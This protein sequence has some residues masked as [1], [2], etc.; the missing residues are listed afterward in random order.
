[1]PVRFKKTVAV[2]DGICTVEESEQLLEW[3]GQHPKGKVNLK[4]C[5]HLHSAVLQ[6]LMAVKPELS[7]PPSDPDMA[8]W[9]LPAIS[10]SS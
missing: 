3:L 2:L 7:S 5:A 1:M 8:S 6:V 4:Q 9:L 10:K